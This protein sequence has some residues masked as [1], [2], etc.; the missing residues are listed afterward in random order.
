MNRAEGARPK[1]RFGQHFLHDQNVVERIL[2]ALNPRTDDHIVEIG[3]G[4]GALTAP[5]LRQI[6][7]LRV[8]ELDRDVI[9][10]LRQAC[11]QHPGLEIIQA[12]ALKFD[13]GALTKADRKTRLLG[14]LPYNISTPL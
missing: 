11:N 12:D 6:S 10:L 8:I 4:R 7:H 14:N 13:F 9:P 1:K 2:R 3:P 5:L